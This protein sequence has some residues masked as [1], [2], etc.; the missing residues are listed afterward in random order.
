MTP[1][2]FHQI[3]AAY[4]ADARRWPEREREAAQEWARAHRDEADAVLS[5]SAGLDA[6]LAADRIEPPSLELQRRIIDGAPSRRPAA[7]WRLWWSGAAVAGVGLLGGVAGALAVSFFVLTENVPV[8][9][10]SSY[11]T[12]S[13][14]GSSADWSGE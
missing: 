5:D 13:F 3:V 11:L 4:G 7:R 14:G 1:E 12:S 10:E 2:R 8:L 6:W 9:H